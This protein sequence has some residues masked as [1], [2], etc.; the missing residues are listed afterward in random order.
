M[1]DLAVYRTLSRYYAHQH[2]YQV[3]SRQ[4]EN[5]LT[6]RAETLILDNSRTIIQEYMGD[7]AGYRTG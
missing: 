7:L 1:G 2:V 5:S 4:D 6:K 3:R